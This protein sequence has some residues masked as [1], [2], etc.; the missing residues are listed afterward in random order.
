MTKAEAAID[1]ARPI[2]DP[3]LH[4][5]HIHSGPNPE[6]QRFL[7]DEAL[8][9]IAASGHAVTHS[10]YVECGQMYRADGPPELR[11]LGETEFVNG[12]AAMSASGGYGPARLGHRIVGNADLSLGARVRDVLEAHLA[13][14]GTR[15]RGVRMETAWS[16]QRLFGYPCDPAHRG[17]MTRPAFV[18]GAQALAALDLSLDVWCLHTQLGELAALADAV[19]GLTIVLDH[20]GT[21]ECG[22][23]WAGRP[24]EAFAQWSEAIRDLALRPNVRV[25]LGGMGMNVAGTL[26]ADDGPGT[27]EEL[28]H[29][30]RARV[31][32]AIA[33]FTPA[34]AMFES[35]FPP[36]R[37]AAS[38][39][40]TWNAFKRLAAGYSEDEKDRLF[41][42]TAAQVYRI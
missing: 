41:R 21:P 40:A 39:G 25:K 23:T 14:A 30:W 28:A 33:A 4:F 22:G 34:R 35:N 8:A 42:G 1:P 3:H 12:I 16:A 19:P 38:Y 27:S 36:D 6:P 13:V 7:F 26:T 37:C 29:E 10:V 24:D 32:T 5:W 20:L 18:E 31:E 11:S 15:F 2:V 9:A 17:V